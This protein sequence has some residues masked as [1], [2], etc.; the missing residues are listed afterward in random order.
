MDS[1]WL[2]DAARYAYGRR[3]RIV[4]HCRNWTNHAR[5]AGLRSIISLDTSADSTIC[6]TLRPGTARIGGKNAAMGIRQLALDGATSVSK[7]SGYL[8][9]MYLTSWS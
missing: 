7:A 2:M 4:Q 3:L 8:W 9:G 5:M 1:G 6:R